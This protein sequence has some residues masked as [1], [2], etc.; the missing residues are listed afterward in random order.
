MKGHINI[1]SPISEVSTSWTRQYGVQLFL[2][3]DDLIHPII[4]GNKWRKL[5]GILANYHKNA[6]DSIT[7]YGGAYSNHLLATAAACSIQKIPCKAIVRGESPAELNPILKMCRMYGMELEFVTRSKYQKTNRKLG[8]SDRILFVPEGGACEEGTH[9]CREILGEVDLSNINQ[10]YVPCGTGT[11]LAGMAKYLE[12]K[13]HE[14]KL[15]GVQVLKGDGYIENEIDSLYGVT[16]IN[17]Y[18]HFHCGGYAKTTDDL[19]F[20]I[21]DFMK[22]TGVLLDPIYNG[23]MM[24]AIYKLLDQ[25]FINRGQRIL[26]IHTGGMTGWFGK[27]NKVSLNE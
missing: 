23:K 19:I 27:F 14:A 12:S 11:T 13:N 16:G 21:Q 10:I 5:S 1:P 22:Q 9:G 4:S 24:F 3:R 20:F 8:V 18:D 25:G 7:T 17:I 26:A 2:K 15:N 6:Y